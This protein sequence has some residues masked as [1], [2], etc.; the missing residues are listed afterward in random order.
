MF[1]LIAVFVLWLLL[2]EE[3]YLYWNLLA[4]AVQ[5][6]KHYLFLGQ[7]FI[8]IMWAIYAT[9][10]IAIGL[11]RK[12]SVLR[13][14]SF[15]LYILVL[16]KVFILDMG[17]RMSSTYRIAGFVVLGVVLI[18]VSYLYQFYKNR[19][20]F[21]DHFLDKPKKETVPKTTS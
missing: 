12:I 4:Q 18:G 3:I 1:A 15:V 19:G 9:S 10:L 21:Q 2:T 20:L 17:A 14:I 8:S 6:P 7:M 16:A 11:W 13:Y 5:N